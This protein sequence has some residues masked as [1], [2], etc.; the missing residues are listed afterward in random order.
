MGDAVRTFTPA[1][2]SSMGR[3]RRASRG[4]AIPFAMLIPIAVVLGI[5]VLWITRDSEPVAN[6]LPSADRL[7]IVASDVL[8]HRHE[9]AT[10]GIWD[11]LPLNTDVSQIPKLLTSEI[12]VPPWVLNN[13]IGS[14]CFI[15]GDSIGDG[16]ELLFVTKMHRLGVLIERAFRWVGDVESDR[17]GGLELRHLPAPGLYYAVRGRVLLVSPARR[18]LIQALTLSPDEALADEDMTRIA[19]DLANQQMGG[20]I[21]FQENDTLADKLAWL[22]F[23][24]R[25][26]PEEAHAKFELELA[27]SWQA[28]IAPLLDNVEPQTLQ[29]PMDGMCVVSA[30]LG[31]PIQAAW[32]ALE[33]LSANPIFSAAQWEAW[34]T[35]TDE[36]QPGLAYMLTRTIGPAGPAFQ[37]SWH[38]LDPYE[39][40]PMP[41]LILTADLADAGAEQVLAAFPA[42]PEGMP[43]YT[44]FPRVD[45]ATRVVTLPLMGGP[46][47]APTAV[48]HDNSLLLSTSSRVAEEMRAEPPAREPLPLPGNLYIRIRPRACVDA[49]ADTGQQFVDIGALKGYTQDSYRDAVAQ[50]RTR[51]DRVKECSALFSHHDG[52]IQGE[53]RV[54]SQTP[55]AK[56]V[57]QAE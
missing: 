42:M 3:K 55:E 29:A 5:Y 32:L 2:R 9:I 11:A 49:L 33:T 46:S 4:C 13:I 17:A 52:L 14:Q 45:A 1:R 51:A 34:T 16:H 18:T 54:V 43:Q 50:W 24:I 40:I 12:D 22:R 56:V 48:F 38:G 39:M 57:A 21:R 7:R 25:F 36:E 20:V 27:D 28:Q 47:I 41:E 15:S 31:K 30:H 37:I 53:I 10:S 26:D 6:H 44:P 8:G 35:L 23:G 19:A